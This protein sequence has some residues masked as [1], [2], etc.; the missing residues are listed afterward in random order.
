MRQWAPII[1][2]AYLPI[3][4]VPSNMDAS[5]LR[6]SIATMEAELVLLKNKVLGLEGSWMHFKL[7]IPP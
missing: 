3:R 6:P 1:C 2:S 4:D 5:G 7:A